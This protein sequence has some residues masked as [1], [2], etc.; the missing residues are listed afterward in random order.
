MISRMRWYSVR[1]W[2]VDDRALEPFDEMIDLDALAGDWF[3]DGRDPHYADLPCYVPLDDED[4]GAISPFID[5]IPIDVRGGR[6]PRRTF[7]R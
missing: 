5:E 2:P 1:S 3:A 7:E 6:L 4:D